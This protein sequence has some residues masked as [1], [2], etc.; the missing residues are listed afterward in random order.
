MASFLKLFVLA[1]SALFPLINPLGS[2]LIFLGLVGH[3]PPE[4]FRRLARK[5]AFTTVP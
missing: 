5:V 4:V 3:A 2:A 1:F